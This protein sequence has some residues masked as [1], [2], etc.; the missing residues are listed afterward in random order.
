MMR[1]DAFKQ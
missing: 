1:I